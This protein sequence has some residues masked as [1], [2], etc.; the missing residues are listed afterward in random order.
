MKR[1]I[2][3]DMKRQVAVEI[4]IFD[5]NGEFKLSQEG[6]IEMVYLQ[7]G[8]VTLWGWEIKLISRKD[9]TSPY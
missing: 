8:W 2:R 4:T 7:K 3:D 9:F 6:Y 5:S 1:G